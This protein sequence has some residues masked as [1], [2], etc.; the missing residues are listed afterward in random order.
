MAV[1]SSFRKFRVKDLS[2]SSNR[3]QVNT[4]SL[5]VHCS[6]LINTSNTNFRGKKVLPFT[7]TKQLAASMTVE[8]ACVFPLF[9]LFAAALLMP[10]QM[11]DQQRKIQTMVER[12]CEELSLYAYVAESEE[13]AEEREYK[14]MTQLFSDVA[15]GVWLK[16]K[17]GD[18]SEYVK[19]KTI[20]VPDTNGNIFIQ[21]DYERTSLLFLSELTVKVSAIRR[22]WKGIEGKL[23]EKD[24]AQGSLADTTMVY[25]GKGMGRY[26]TYRDCHYIS[27]DYQAISE[28]EAKGMKDEDGRRLTAC[29]SCGDKTIEGG[30]VYVTPEGRHYH[31]NTDCLAMISYVQKV[32][33]SEV[34]YLGECSYCKKKK[35]TE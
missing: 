13:P 17:L 22:S 9:L 15:A 11:L 34:W 8:A 12:T 1:L 5:Q 32:P 20:R 19:V 2:I 30:I 27:N 21:A 33:L 16:S 29:G 35:G 10:M 3:I 26:H 31:T 28:D 24:T 7:F 18:L 6:P 23:T 25:I 14:E 4:T